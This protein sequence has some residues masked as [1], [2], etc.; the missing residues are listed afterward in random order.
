MRVRGS[1]SL[2]IKFP[3]ADLTN[4]TIR[5]PQTSRQHNATNKG[6]ITVTSTL[7]RIAD[8]G[9]SSLV[10]ILQYYIRLHNF[11]PIDHL[12]GKVTYDTTP[13]AII[14]SIQDLR[15]SPLVK[16]KNMLQ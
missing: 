10:Q 16:V 9:L 7:L 1:T 5:P 4:A 3:Q 2:I 14:R 11:L 6:W 15:K 12:G 13:S 8:R